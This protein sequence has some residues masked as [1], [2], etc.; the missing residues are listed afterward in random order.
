MYHLYLIAA[1][2]LDEVSASAVDGEYIVVF[3]D[4]VS[5]EEGLLHEGRRYN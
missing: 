1:P 4:S 5:E 3:H 2:L